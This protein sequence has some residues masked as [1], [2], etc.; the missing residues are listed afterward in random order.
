MN[1]TIRDASPND[2][3]R[4]ARFN[5]AMAAETENRKL[6]STVIKAGVAAVLADP[7]KGR[8]WLAERDGQPVGQIMITWEWSDW[9]NGMQ[10]WIQSVYVHPDYRRQGV[11]AALYR[12]VESLARSHP[13]ACG[14]RLYVENGNSRAQQIYEVLGMTRPGYQVME[15]DFRQ[16]IPDE[17]QAHAEN[18]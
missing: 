1:L 9:R 11:F 10:W 16:P 2:I 15:V 5:S 14:L 7:A 8:Y 13:D 6:D 17:K 18:R 12:H 3:D 4:I